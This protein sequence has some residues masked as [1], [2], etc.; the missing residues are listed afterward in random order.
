MLLVRRQLRVG[1]AF[2]LSHLRRCF[3]G[4]HPC[5]DK[6]VGERRVPWVSGRAGPDAPSRLRAWR[7]PRSDRRAARSRPSR[8]RLRAPRLAPRPPGRTLQPRVGGPTGSLVPLGACRLPVGFPVGPRQVPLG[9]R[10]GLSKRA[11]KSEWEH[12]GSASVVPLGP[13]AFGEAPSPSP[14]RRREAHPACSHW[15]A[16]PLPCARNLCLPLGYLPR[17]VLTYAV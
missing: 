8:A 16:A 9:A 13:S 7:T 11:S 15:E 1:H 17:Q 6:R 10:V 12:G 14:T 2:P 3:V 5:Q 4:R